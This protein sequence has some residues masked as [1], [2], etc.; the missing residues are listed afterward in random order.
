MVHKKVLFF[1]LGLFPLCVRAQTITQEEF[2]NDL[3]EHHPV[4]KKE[5]LSAQI[6]EQDQQRYIGS[7]DWNAF[8]ATTFSHEVPL[9]AMYPVG[10]LYMTPEYGTVD[11]T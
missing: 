8:A 6:E 5:R 10:E 9:I 4:F 1:C 2:L 11:T 3:I 7:E